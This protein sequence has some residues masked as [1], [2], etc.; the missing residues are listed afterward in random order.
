MFIRSK[1]L[2]R[3]KNKNLQCL[4]FLKTSERRLTQ[5][6]FKNVMLETVFLNSLSEFHGPKCQEMRFL[7]CQFSKIFWGSIPPGPPRNNG[8]KPIVWVLRTH[9]GLLFTR[10]WLLKNLSTTLEGLKFLQFSHVNSGLKANPGWHFW[11]KNHVVLCCFSVCAS[12]PP[13]IPLYFL[14]F[15]FVI[16]LAHGFSF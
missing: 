9:N 10:L 12:G 5:G 15:L 6:Q 11:S 8:L 2:G 13:T 14:G 16:F 3:N 1:L 4:S 7:V